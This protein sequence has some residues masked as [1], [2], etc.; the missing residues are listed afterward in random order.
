[1]TK[2][3]MEGLCHHMLEIIM[4]FLLNCWVKNY[5]KTIRNMTGVVECLLTEVIQ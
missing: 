4:C 2:T 3:I 5:M 1:M